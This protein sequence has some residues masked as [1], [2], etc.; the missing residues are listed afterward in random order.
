MATPELLDTEF[1]D[2]SLWFS[3]EASKDEEGRLFDLTRAIRLVFLMENAGLSFWN[4]LDEAVQKRDKPLLVDCT[5]F[6]ANY[7]IEEV[8]AHRT[9]NP[10]KED[11]KPEEFLLNPGV[12][13]QLHCN[14]VLFNQWLMTALFAVLNIERI[15]TALLRYLPIPEKVAPVVRDLLVFTRDLHKR[16]N[17][18]FLLL[19][20]QIKIYPRKDEQLTKL[21]MEDVVAPCVA[22]LKVI[23]EN[24]HYT[25]VYNML[26]V[27]IFPGSE[28]GKRGIYMDP[29]NYSLDSENENFDFVYSLKYW[30]AEA[31]RN[32]FGDLKT[33]IEDVKKKINESKKFPFLE[34]LPIV[35]SDLDKAATKWHRI[36]TLYQ[37]NI[38]CKDE[39][40]DSDRFKAY[41]TNLQENTKMICWILESTGLDSSCIL[42]LLTEEQLIL[43][44][45][46]EAR[47]MVT[48]DK[49]D[50]LKTQME[51]TPELK[52]KAILNIEKLGEN[53][54]QNA[55]AEHLKEWDGHSFIPTGYVQMLDQQARLQN[56][57]EEQV[58]Q[59]AKQMVYSE[60]KYPD[61]AFVYF[62]LPPF[63]TCFRQKPSQLSEFFLEE[64]L[65]LLNKDLDA[66][67]SVL[68]F[69]VTNRNLSGD[70]VTS[71]LAQRNTLLEK[72][73]KI[74]ARKFGNTCAPIL[75]LS[76]KLLDV[77]A[78]KAASKH[79]TLHQ[80]FSTWTGRG[81]TWIDMMSFALT[82]A[83]AR[84]APDPQ[85]QLK[86]LLLAIFCMVDLVCL[87]ESKSAKHEAQRDDLLARLHA[88][89]D[90]AYAEL[91][92]EKQV[93]NK[94]SKLDATVWQRL[95][96]VVHLLY[97]MCKVAQVPQ[98][99]TPP[100][101]YPEDSK[102]II[103]HFIQK[104]LSRLRNAVVALC[105]G[106]NRQDRTS[107]PTQVMKEFPGNLFHPYL[108]R[109]KKGR[110]RSWEEDL[111]LP[112]KHCRF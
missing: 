6:V 28:L 34:K 86:S 97:E 93:P 3:A 21:I 58:F 43:L 50:Y 12:L 72:I 38:D 66:W 40:E 59:L 78:E 49:L 32:C 15:R 63:V 14:P 8:A 20:Q 39:I 13:W 61:W 67:R 91:M 79:P 74:L 70:Y 57:I 42:T 82:E 24:K 31:P 33:K 19:G 65:S 104:D 30:V 18:G 76:S 102:V 87:N 48:E 83:A 94:K 110:I 88:T 103:K 109:I 36:A 96:V 107:T 17:Y 16:L 22:A 7:S 23:L 51:C 56:P 71:L 73:C 10:P 108:W 90:P 44:N 112:V 25:M 2:C 68:E 4:V 64:L 92:G 29:G 45:H 52:Q 75:K 80:T 101:N 62:I 11:W 111:L 85:L 26:K 46:V 77:E 37:L 55:A 105:L 60:P 81:A 41:L 69:S 84:F 47:I 9:K 98:N 95:G 54:F 53:L 27:A 5:Y 99:F 100:P 106:L 1:Y 89:L 35:I